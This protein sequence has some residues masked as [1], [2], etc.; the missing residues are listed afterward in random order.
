MGL[1]ATVLGEFSWVPPAWLRRIGVGR[2]GWSLLALFV[3]AGMATGAYLY[4][5]S[6]PKPLRVT[7]SVEAPGVTAI[8]DDELEPDPLR[9]STRCSGRPPICLATPPILSAIT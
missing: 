9:S 1:C 7:I 3:G 4:Y 2:A 8:V 6:L 5:Q